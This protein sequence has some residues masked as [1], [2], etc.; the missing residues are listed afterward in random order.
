MQRLNQF[1]T[2]TLLAASLAA[3]QTPANRTDQVPK[4]SRAVPAPA[5]SWA[6][7]WSDTIPCADCPGILTRLDLRADS[8]Y[9]LRSLYLERDSIPQ[10][11][12]GKWTVMDDILVLATADVPMRWGVKGDALEMLGPDGR[13]AESALPYAIQRTAIPDTAPMHLEGSVHPHGGL[14]HI[15][16]P[17]FARQCV[18]HMPV[19]L[20]RTKVFHGPHRRSAHP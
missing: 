1:L 15:V 20:F 8:T 13:P 18:S 11:Q 17:P 2:C 7:S 9:V 6:G 5:F 4:H 12:I 3:C 19:S 10:G 14:H 16:P